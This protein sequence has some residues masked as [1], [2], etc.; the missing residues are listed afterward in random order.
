VTSTFHTKR[1]APRT[2]LS[3][4]LSVAENFCC[5]RVLGLGTWHP[6]AWL[7]PVDN[8]LWPQLLAPPACSAGVLSCCPS[9]RSSQATN[10]TT[11][12]GPKV[13]THPHRKVS[14]NVSQVRSHLGSL[15]R[16]LGH[17]H[18]FSIS[19][20]SISLHLSLNQKISLSQPQIK[21][22]LHHHSSVA[23]HRDLP[24]NGSQHCLHQPTSPTAHS[25]SPCVV[26]FTSLL[27]MLC[28]PSRCY[29]AQRL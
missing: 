24:K 27:C 16:K 14:N 7:R 10:C 23:G 11:A 13:R 17:P 29:A 28:P 12:Q 3:E 4:L 19:L 25:H 8:T 20:K 18:L 6:C 2:L 1:T 21:Q 9:S 26:P 22:V 5:W 15:S